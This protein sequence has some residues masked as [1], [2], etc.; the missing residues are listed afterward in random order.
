[1]KSVKWIIILLFSLG[2]AG[3]RAQTSLTVMEKSGTLSSFNLGDIQKLVF[4]S[5]TMTINKLD[6]NIRDFNMSDVRNLNFAENALLSENTEEI[7][8]MLL[9]PN[10][11]RDHLRVS[12]E[13]TSEENI[14]VTI[15]N[16][17]GAVVFQ[18]H[19]K[20]HAGTNTVNIPVLTFQKGMYLFKIQKGNEIEIRKFI[21]N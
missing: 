21:K 18:Q 6:G 19:M 8:N 10:P 11:V 1:M 5:G 12:Y 3:V 9:Y 2:I 16:I 7:A 15:I 17:Q 14:S 4:A 20:S 13:C